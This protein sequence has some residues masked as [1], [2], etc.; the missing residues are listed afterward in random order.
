LSQK[1]GIQIEIN[2]LAPLAFG[3]RSATESTMPSGVVMEPVHSLKEVADGVH[4]KAPMHG[5]SLETYLQNR[6]GN[7]TRYTNTMVLLY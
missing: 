7:D 4:G 3:P 1:I 5:A 6:D 2:N